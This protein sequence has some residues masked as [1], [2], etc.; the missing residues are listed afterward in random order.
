M[1]PYPFS[2]GVFIWGNPIWV[3]GETDKNGIEKKRKE[4]EEAL[5][6]ITKEAD[7]FFMKE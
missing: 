6:R 1:I 5:N 2:K 3:S 7:E 4:L